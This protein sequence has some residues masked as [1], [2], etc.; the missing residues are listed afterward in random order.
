MWNAII[1]RK[2]QLTWII[3][4]HA[5][6]YFNLNKNYTNVTKKDTENAGFEKKKIFLYECQRSKRTSKFRPN[7]VKRSHCCFEDNNTVVKTNF[8]DEFFL[9]ESQFLYGISYKKLGNQQIL[10]LLT[11]NSVLVQKNIRNEI[12]L[13]TRSILSAFN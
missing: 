5:K 3:Y 4:N 1:L 10:K 12:F 7:L 13:L 6:K 2:Q 9:N 8:R 11:F